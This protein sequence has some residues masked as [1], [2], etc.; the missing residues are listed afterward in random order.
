MTGTRTIWLLVAT[1]LLLLAGAN[2]HLVYVA[3]R[4]QPACVAHLKPGEAGGLS[5]ARS[6][7]TPS[8]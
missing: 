2:A 8:R 7:C 1:G 5:A 4:S 3:L 6:A